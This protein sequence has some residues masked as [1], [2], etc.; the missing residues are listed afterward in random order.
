MPRR[1]GKV[2]RYLPY[3]PGNEP[4]ARKGD[5]DADDGEKVSSKSPRHVVVLLSVAQKPLLSS[6]GYQAQ[7]A[8]CGLWEQLNGEEVKFRGLGSSASIRRA[9]SVPVAAKG[10]ATHS[11][12]RICTVTKS[13]RRCPRPRWRRRRETEHSYT[14]RCRRRPRRKDLPW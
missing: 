11:G 9:Q 1:D 6:G 10:S 8:C 5:A 2:G 3:L 12:I 13:M 14:I 4:G 7:G